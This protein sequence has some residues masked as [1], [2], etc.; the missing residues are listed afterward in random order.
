MSTRKYH[1]QINNWGKKYCQ[2]RN[3]T[4]ANKCR[5][6]MAIPYLSSLTSIYWARRISEF[7]LLSLYGA[8]LVWLSVRRSRLHK[9]T[10][11]QAFYQKKNTYTAIRSVP[12]LQ[13]SSLWNNVHVCDKSKHWKAFKFVLMY[14]C[15][16]FQ[17]SSF[18]NRL[19]MFIE[20]IYVLWTLFFRERSGLHPWTIVKVWFPTLNYKTR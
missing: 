13:L 18:M 12:E 2:R 19:E 6:C 5:I 20:K 15:L 16:R 3:W 11:R 4:Q 9:H 10:R 1:C 7:C 8:A 14:H 17:L